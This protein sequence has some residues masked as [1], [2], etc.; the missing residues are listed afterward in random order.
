MDAN[1]HVY[2][3]LVIL[4]TELKSATEKVVCSIYLLLRI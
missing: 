1:I 3:L 2:Q 4:C